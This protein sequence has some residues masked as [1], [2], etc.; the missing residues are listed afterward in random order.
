MVSSGRRCVNPERV[1]AERRML[2]PACNRVTIQAQQQL[3]LFLKCTELNQ[4]NEKRV[5]YDTVRV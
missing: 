4:K 1:G 5:D 2:N 3:F